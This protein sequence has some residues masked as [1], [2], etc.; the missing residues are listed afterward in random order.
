MT[1]RSTRF[2]TTVG[3]TNTRLGAAKRG[4]GVE[5]A[6]RLA[7]RVDAPVCLVGADPTDR[8]VERRRQ[9]LTA[10]G[11]CATMR[12][13]KGPHAL[14]A[15][16]IPHRKLCVVSLSDRTAVESVLPELRD[17]FEYVVVD[18]P[19]RV[20]GGIGISRVLLPHLD[21]LLVASGYTAGELALTRLYVETLDI[22]SRLNDVAI[23]VVLVGTADDSGLSDDQ[24]ERRLRAL[25]VVGEVPRLWGRPIPLVLAGDTALDDAFAPITDWS[26]A[27]R[28]HFV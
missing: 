12:I 17:M 28:R 1:H 14:E 3:I 25:P 22:M 8:D 27:R 5:L 20:G 18:G 11:K 16:V 6:L 19:S 10:G 24:L 4:L 23:G 21:G 2:G 9:D 13:V 15:T 7:R 26:S